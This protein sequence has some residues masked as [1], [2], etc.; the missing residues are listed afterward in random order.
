M[1]RNSVSFNYIVTIQALSVYGLVHQAVGFCGLLKSSLALSKGN[2]TLPCLA[3]QD[4]LDE[5][6]VFI[7]EKMYSDVIVFVYIHAKKELKVKVKIF[8][9]CLI[10]KIS[11][12]GKSQAIL[13]G[14][15]FLLMHFI[16][17]CVIMIFICL[18]IQCVDISCLVSGIS[19]TFRK[20]IC[21]TS[22]S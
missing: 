3:E 2:K 9:K 18:S 8:I 5:R 6:H 11:S 22:H 19:G 7:I 12:K 10:Q 17:G 20:A 16:N 1:L 14:F 4:C 13:V 15:C 21:T